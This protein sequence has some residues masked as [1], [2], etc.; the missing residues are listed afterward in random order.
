MRDSIETIVRRAITPS[1]VRITGS[2]TDPRSYG[3]YRLPSNCGATRRYRFG[4][5]PIRK[6]ELAQ[7][8]KHCALMY[9]FRSRADAMA[10]AASLNASKSLTSRT[11][12][13]A[14]SS[15]KYLFLDFYEGAG[16][17]TIWC[18]RDLDTD[19]SSQEFSSEEAALEAFGNDELQFSRLD[20]LGD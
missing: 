20:N 5:H 9:L 11:N 13:V 10:V 3:V 15:R 14:K 2:L 1:S 17:R 19:E 7:E 18:W 6:Q 12:R 4:N 8:F 16:L